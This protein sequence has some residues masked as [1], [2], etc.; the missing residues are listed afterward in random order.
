MK[1]RMLASMLGTISTDVDAVAAAP[2]QAWA[3]ASA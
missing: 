3:I 2:A 1:V